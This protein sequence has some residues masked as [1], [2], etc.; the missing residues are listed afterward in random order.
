MKKII[1]VFIATVI[2]ISSFV[3]VFAV[4]LN[5]IQES[6]DINGFINGITELAREYD[7]DKEFTVPEN[8]EIS[9]IQDP[10]APNAD[11]ET[12]EVRANTF[13]ASASEETENGDTDKYT[14]QDFQT[15]RLIVRANGKFDKFG[16]L[17]DVSGFED[18]HI[19]QYE[20]PEAAMESYANLQ[21]EKNVTSIEPDLIV[22][23]LSSESEE[24]T[25]VDEQ[26]NSTNHLTPWSLQRTQADRLLDYLETADISMETVTVAVIDSGI[27]YNHEFLKDRVDKTGFNSSSD[28]TPG[29]EMDVEIC[30]GTMVASVIV[31]NT[32]NNV[33]IKGYKAL[34]NGYYGSTAGA[35][36]AILKAVADNVDVINLSITFSTNTMLS[37]KALKTAFE[38]DISVVCAAGNSGMIQTIHAPE[39]IEECITVGAT[40]RDNIMT[41]FSDKSWNVDVSAPGQNI[42]TA[43]IN[44]Q[45]ELSDGT[46]F[47]APCVASLVAIIR[48]IYP[49]MT[50]KQ[51]E[52][53]IKES[54]KP[55]KNIYNY[56]SHLDGTGMVQFCD[57]L[58]LPALTGVETNLT[59]Y[60]YNTPQ[61]CTLSCADESAK[62]LFTADGTYPD[63]E[64]ANEYTNPIDIDEFANI[65]AVAYYAN[66]GYYS[67]EI[68]FTVRI[69]TIGA[70]RDFEINK[71]GIITN[72]NGNVGDLIIPDTINGITVTGIKKGAFK[73]ASIYGLT[74][75]KTITEL[76]QETLRYHETLAYIDGE[77]VL[78]IDKAALDGAES[79]LEA[80]FPNVVTIDKYAF[81]NTHN[82]TSLR[83]DNLERIE[84]YAFDDSGLYAF[85]GPLVT[86]VNASAF[87]ECDF[88]ETLYLPNWET[89]ETGTNGKTNALLF[90]TTVLN[91]ADF[92]KL[93]FLQDGM[94]RYSGVE[95]VHLPSVTKMDF[96]VF[97]NCPSLEYV[98]MPN[99]VTIPR[100]TFRDSGNNSLIH[101]TYVFDSVTEIEE[102]AFQNSYAN[103]LEFSQLETAKSL[104]KYIANG[105]YPFCVISMPSTFKE[106]TEDTKGRNYKVY[107]TKGTY[108]E[109]WA[110][111][112]GH[113]FIEISQ[114]TAILQDVPM[115]YTDKT[116]ILSPDVIGFNRTYQWH[117]SFTADNTAG[118]PIDG[119]TDKEFNPAKYPAY[120]YY[121]CV[122]TSTD[123]GYGPIEIRTGVTANKVASADYSAYDAAV[124]KANSLEREYYKDLT[125]LDAA[126]AVDVHGLTI[127]EQAIVDAQTKAIEDVLIA[128]ELKDAD[129]SAYNA[130][131]E[132]A[133]AL[134]KNLYADTTELDK[135]LAEDISGLTIINQDT[136][137]N[138]TLAIED[139]LKNLVLKPADYTE[140]YKAVEQ[141]K[142]LDRS[143]YEDLTAVDEALAVD[144]S[145]KNITEQAD[146]DNQTQKILNAIFGLAYKPADYSEVEKA[147][148]SIPE[149]LSVYTDESVSALQETLNAVDYS[150]NITEQTTIKGYAKAITDAVN[151]L[152]YK[153]ADYAEV[154]KAIASIPKDLSVYTDESVSTLQETLNTVDYSL[155]ITEQ[156]TV[157]GYAKTIMDA[158]N[159]LE[160]K[161]VE[162]PVTVPTEPG[163]PAEPTQPATPDDTPNPD[164][165]NTGTEHAIVFSFTF[166][167]L[168]GTIV[169]TSTRRKE[170]I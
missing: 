83:F 166:L 96:M 26:F 157:D 156:E 79:L 103:R 155:N 143:L 57:A 43:K 108:A 145:G 148:A 56:V 114:E 36:A 45:Y 141:A 118:A 91:V 153:P 78:Y 163:E 23:M 139:A 24:L 150:L 88:L 4:P 10:S 158:I 105:C 124:L 63:V 13:A 76:S 122:V 28:G 140:Y 66:S 72:Y 142:S 121:Y 20:S 6:K 165:P 47:S 125:A 74:L 58:G 116:Q 42:L 144:V 44:N 67:D 110:N 123:V 41:D 138:Q 64:T 50:S 113:E 9:Q 117:G 160:L 51:I 90:R 40:S 65:R 100:N 15:A 60:K 59:E 109:Q 53:R 17:E 154:K 31:D 115:E 99:L 164:I 46:S 16:A 161:P 112:N 1:S 2:T 80:N 34:G 87:N 86:V 19:L 170:K 159:G 128:L 70:E 147:T 89:T 106:C 55:V 134:D 95:E 32:P 37:I 167:C 39:N 111:K 120:P 62:I 101:T 136:V 92:P 68:D 107:G 162:P 38:A 52:K 29:D 132:K 27:D 152:V 8:D 7:A 84:D 25:K 81:R 85:Y 35:T 21:L 97:A 33:R 3:T 149:D 18:F 54:A 73:N 11:T 93:T 127:T 49:D 30:H 169:F 129:Y 61:M 22:Q 146:V 5:D 71:N 104:P 69:R 77:G 12:N 130:A 82:M 137:D 133:N 14:L 135:L 98:Y 94:F 168:C 48:S 131:V 102:N 75:P 126:L 119:A 151:G